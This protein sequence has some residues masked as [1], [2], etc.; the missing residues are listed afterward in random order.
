MFNFLRAFFVVVMTSPFVLATQE[1][2]QTPRN[3]VGVGLITG[4]KYPG[5]KSTRTLPIPFWSLEWKQLY[6]QGL[7]LVGLHAVRTPTFQVL[8]AFQYDLS[9]RSEKRDS[10]LRGMGDVRATPKAKLTARYKRSLYALSINAAQDIGRNGHGL[11]GG[12]DATVAIPF[13]PR[14][15]FNFGPGVTLANRQSMQTFFGVT[16]SQS[17]TSTFPAYAARGG[18]M[19]WHVKALASYALTPRWSLTSI[20]SQAWL[21]GDAGKSPITQTRSQTS[22][23]FSVGYSF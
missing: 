21:I 5:A 15:F 10:R 4:P 7:E 19:D 1:R 8:T 20:V 9:G 16:E 6:S 3:Q 2:T 22:V 17:R 12:V 13:I 18:L 14:W 23:I 11:L